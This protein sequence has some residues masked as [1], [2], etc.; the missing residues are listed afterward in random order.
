MR[1]ILV[2]A[3][4]LSLAVSGC[5]MFKQQDSGQAP[6]QPRPEAVNQAFYGFADVPVP[7]EL[8]YVREKS[9]VYETQSLKAG[10]MVLSGNVDMMSLENYFKLNLPKNGWR[11]LNSYRYKDVVMNFAKEDR[12]C[13]IR[14]SRGSFNTEVEIW[15]GPAAR[16]TPPPKEGSFRGN[17][18]K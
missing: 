11:L 7:K 16:E 8:E 13:N 1:K 12:T 15:V 2:C 4:L 10:V 6:P 9:F 17:G 5:A 3:L 18:P 14:M